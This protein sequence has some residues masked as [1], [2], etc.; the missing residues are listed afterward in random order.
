MKTTS[1]PET[2][3]LLSKILSW[4]ASRTKV[5][6]RE[7]RFTKLTRWIKWSDLRMSKSPNWRTKSSSTKKR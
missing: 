3:W 4:Q 1:K 7:L 5:E 6:A 2:N